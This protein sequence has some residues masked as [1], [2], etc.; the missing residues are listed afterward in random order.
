MCLIYSR[1]KKNDSSKVK[2]EAKK[3]SKAASAA[4]VRSS[5]PS[6]VHSCWSCAQTGISLSLCSVC[7][8]ARYCGE[9]CQLED[10]GRHKR[11]CRSRGERKKSVKSLVEIDRSD[12][13]D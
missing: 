7:R 3:K 6:S 13:V 12:E 1:A 5:N 4:S 10:W 2:R 8:K 11:R 9:T